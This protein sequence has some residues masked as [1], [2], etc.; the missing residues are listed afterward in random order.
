MVHH[1]AGRAESTL[2]VSQAVVMTSAEAQLESNTGSP[3]ATG[4]MVATAEQ[5]AEA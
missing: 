1:E 5:R 4:R 2:A 3:T